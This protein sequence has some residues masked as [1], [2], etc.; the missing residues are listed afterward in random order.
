MPDY[1]LQLIVMAVI[2]RIFVEKV[3]IAGGLLDLFGVYG[4][5][6]EAVLLAF[7]LGAQTFIIE[8]LLTYETRRCP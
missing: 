7:N 5:L 3:M 8:S 1:S 6:G 4:R 2:D